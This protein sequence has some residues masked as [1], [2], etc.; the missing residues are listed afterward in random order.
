[1]GHSGHFAAQTSC[2]L[3]SQKRTFDGARRKAIANID[4]NDAMILLYDANLS[5]MEFSERTV[6]FSE[7]ETILL[8]WRRDHQ[9]SVLRRHAHRHFRIAAHRHDEQCVDPERWLATNTRREGS[10]GRL[11]TPG[12]PK[13]SG[14][15]VAHGRSDGKFAARGGTGPLRVHDMRQAER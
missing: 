8:G 14:T 5:R 9:V 15:L 2:P 4:L 1:M 6:V 11:G 7:F 10:G 13:V 3:Y 12:S